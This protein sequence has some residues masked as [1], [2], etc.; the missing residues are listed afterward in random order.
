MK[1]RQGGRSIDNENGLILIAALTLLTA[2]ILAGATAFIVASTDVKVSSNFKN[3]QTALRVAM[4]GAEKARETLRAA[5]A[6]STDTTN[7]S[8][9]LVAYAS[10]PLA[11]SSSLVTGYAYTASLAN[12]TAAGE[13]STTDANGKVVITSTATGPKNSKAIVTTVV[14]LY[15]LSTGSPAVV[16]SKDN[17]TLSGSSLSIDGNDGGACGS[18]NLG[19]VYTMDPSTTT[20]NGNPPLTGNPST[21]QHGTVDIDLQALVD[22]FKPSA[23]YTLTDDVSGATYGSASN[24]VTVYA[25]AVGTQA[26]GEL[27]LNNV[28]GYG[29]LIVKCKWPGISTGTESSSLPA[30]LVRRGV[31]PT[32]RIFRDRFIL[33]VLPSAIPLSAATSISPTTVAR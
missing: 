29:I 9:E 18:G 12:D 13:T 11:S 17:V 14:Q 10:T 8:E 20:T 25:D 15:T 32:Q 23:N 31:A 30:F 33:E 5:N 16:Y 2:L 21:P 22:Q 28:T 6:S 3:N 1:R 7:F 4:A 26:D 27:R 19:T 24:Y